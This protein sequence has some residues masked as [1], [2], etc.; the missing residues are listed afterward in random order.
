MTLLGRGEKTA[1]CVGYGLSGVLDKAS[2]MKCG[3]G[4][5]G[6]VVIYQLKL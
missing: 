2:A 3:G 6:V 5:G 1:L 4:V